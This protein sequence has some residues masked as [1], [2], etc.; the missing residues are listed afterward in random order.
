MEIFL[1]L[2]YYLEYIFWFVLVF[3]II[4]FIH[5]FG[6]FYVA[7]ANKVKVDRFSIG[8]GKPLVKFRDSKNTIWQLCLIPLGGY[9][10]FSGEMYPEKSERKEKKINSE[11]FMNKTSLQKASIVL[12]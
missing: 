8:F 2:F 3:S 4:V 5:E 9:V 7:K 1:K 12:A 10:K 11:L 6:H